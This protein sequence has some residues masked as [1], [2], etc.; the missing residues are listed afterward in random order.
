MDV[1]GIGGGSHPRRASRVAVILAAVLAVSLASCSSTSSS[2]TSGSASA[3]GSSGTS[4]TAPI[5]KSAFSDHT[6][7]T[8]SSVR[9]GNVSTLQFSLFK[10]AYVGTQAYAD[11]VNSHGGVNGRKLEVDSYNDMYSGQP[12]K[13]ETQQAVQSDFALVGGFSLQDNYGETVLAAN[14]QVPNVTVSLNLAAGSLPNSF[15]PDPLAHGWQLGPLVYFK[16]KFPSEISHAGALIADQP[17]A[18]FAWSGEK[19]A[20]Q[21]IG[22]NV[23]YDPTFDITQTQFSQNVIAMRNAGVKILFL[24][25]MPYNYAGAVITALNQQDFHPV[26]VL[27]GST[28]SKALVPKAGGASA[29]DGAY[30]NQ[31]TSLFLGEDAT[32]LPSVQTFQTWVQ[33]ASPGF[34]ADL[35]TL[36]G[37][38][39]AELFAQ[40]LQ[41]AGP[42]PSRGSVLQQLRTITTFSGGYIVG[43]ANPAKKIPTNC[44]IIAR[45]EHGTFVRLDDP[46]VSSS[47]HGYRCD[48]PYRYYKS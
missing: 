6:G 33:K 16:N 20:M 24:E 30:L 40:A 36:F 3:Q 7:I 31:G 45:I 26:V 35:Y 46:A 32:K 10:G 44:Y 28:Y 41:Q 29:I 5:P 18:E 1:S 17:A 23:V 42:D 9:I 38:T 27:G 37:W 39:S 21:S 14:P 11:Y 34:Q 15:S 4:R 2:T 19:Q 22:Y 12:N 48:Q 13:Q 8:S 43:P 47:A 25:Q